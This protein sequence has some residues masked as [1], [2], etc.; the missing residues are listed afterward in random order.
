MRFIPVAALFAMT[1]SPAAAQ[2]PQNPMQPGRWEI[3]MQMSMPG[4]PMEMPAQKVT[5]CVTKKQLED[6]N[7]AVPGAPGGTNPCKVTN[8]KVDGHKVTWNMTCSE[9]QAMTGS[10]EIIVNGDTYT[11]TMK[12]TSD[13]GQMTMKYNAKRLGDCEE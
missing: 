9:P 11:G 7:G 5:Q 4:M 8:H 13:Q 10:G 2:A 3:T 12:M 1:L 6:P